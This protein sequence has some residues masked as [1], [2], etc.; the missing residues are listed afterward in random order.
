MWI[1]ALTEQISARRIKII[2]IITWRKDEENFGFLCV[3]GQ[4]GNSSQVAHQLCPKKIDQC[5]LPQRM[6]AW[7]RQE[8]I[9]CLIRIALRLEAIASRLEAIA[10]QF[11][12]IA[13]RLEAIALRV[14]AITL[15]VGWRPSLFFLGWRPS[16]LG[17]RPSLL[18]WRPSLVGWRPSLLDGIEALNSLQVAKAMNP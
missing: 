13:S 17:W 14:E 15:R 9:V 6:V 4:I 10:L 1:V 16:L 11:E 8:W 7:E 12:A 2:V 18:A 5:Y 3:K